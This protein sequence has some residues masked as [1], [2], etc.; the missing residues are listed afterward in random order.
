MNLLGLFDT[1]LQDISRPGNK[2][3]TGSRKPAHEHAD[4]ITSESESET[5]SEDIAKYTAEGFDYK[6]WEK[7]EVPSDIRDLFQY[8]SR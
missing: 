3:V 7:L 8:I 6:Q 5:E 1:S 4:G 2:P